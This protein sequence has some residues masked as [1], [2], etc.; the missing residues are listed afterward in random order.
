MSNSDTPFVRN[1]YKGFE[2]KEI[3]NRREINLQSKDR[4]VT[5]LLLTNYPIPKLKL[6]LFPDWE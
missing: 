3:E 5:E 2:I 4:S 6:P 1:L